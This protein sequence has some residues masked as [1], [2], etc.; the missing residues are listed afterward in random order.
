MD[1]EGFGKAFKIIFIPTIPLQNKE[2][3]YTSYSRELLRRHT[4]VLNIE[5]NL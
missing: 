1:I 5:W 2:K 3:K 4:R